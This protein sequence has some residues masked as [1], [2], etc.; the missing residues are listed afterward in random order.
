MWQMHSLCFPETSHLKIRWNTPGNAGTETSQSGIQSD[1]RVPHATVTAP[2]RPARDD[3]FDDAL[4]AQP[5][6]F[7]VATEDLS[8]QHDA[9]SKD[10][11]GP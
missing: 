3:L 10:P 8:A 2:R 4:R 1:H 11:A 7:H 9:T 6:T 5:P